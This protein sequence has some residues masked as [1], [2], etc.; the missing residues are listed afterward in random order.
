[1][2]HV[3]IQR[4]IERYKRPVKLN[5]G[6]SET[7]PAYCIRE[8]VTNRS[9]CVTKSAKCWPTALRRFGATHLRRTCIWKLIGNEPEGRGSGFRLL[10]PIQSK[11]AQS[12]L[13]L[14]LMPGCKAG[15]AP[16]DGNAYQVSAARQI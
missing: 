2:E 3:E 11:L 7:I 10:P 15:L 16:G 6:V 1:M 12:K 4:R 9:L 5:F 8:V 14:A 13:A